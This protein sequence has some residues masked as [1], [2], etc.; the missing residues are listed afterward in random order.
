VNTLATDRRSVT[1]SSARLPLSS[2]FCRTTAQ[3]SR[4]H[5]IV[6]LTL[7]WTLPSATS[8]AAVAPVRF[9]DVV[10]IS[11]RQVGI[12]DGYDLHHLALFACIEDTGHHRC[13]PIP[14]Q[15]DEVDAQEHWVL[16]QGPQPNADTPPGV[17]DANDRLLFMATDAGDRARRADLSPGIAAAEIAVHDPLTGNT[18][19]AYLMAYPGDGPR[20]A[21]SYVA[22]DPATDRVRGQRVTLG[23]RHGVPGYLA[24]DGTGNSADSAT[25]TPLLDRFKVRATATFLWGLVHFSRNED[26]ITTE[27]VAWRQGPIRVIRRQRQWVRIG[28]GIHS[29]TFGSYT[30]F[31]RDFAELPVGLYLNF[32][33]TY[34]FGDIV[35]R[36]FLD[37]R[38]LRGWW[39]VLPNV[40]DPIPV[41]GMMNEKKEALRQ[42]P[43]SW[44]ALR[45]PQ[46]TLV[47]MLDVGPSLASVRRRLVY[48]ETAIRSE[49]PEE[50][51]GE[52]PAIGYAL[53]RW[54]HVSAG[55]HQMASTSYALPSDVDIHQ[56]I[57]AR[58]SPL[59]VTVQPLP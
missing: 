29:P 13:D 5:L 45:G 51:P 50:V 15:A 38:D 30:Y 34:F 59:Q 12:F 9:A 26:D 41:D 23:F 56:F 49:P 16:D 4:A 3:S 21:R 35:V 42:L 58:Q 31:Y 37:F 57:A 1:L 10:S 44:F 46:V 54:E 20:A 33:P 43:A 55:A 39:L 25:I 22:Y 18:S 28:W 17:L 11:G 40:P 47:Q 32:P 52:E 7:L 14:F 2:N 36:A 27:F 6:A 24:I 19:W 8:A 48:N 53:D